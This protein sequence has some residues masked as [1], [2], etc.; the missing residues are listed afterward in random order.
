MVAAGLNFNRTLW[1]PPGASPAVVRTYVDAVT[2]MYKDQQFRKDVD[3]LV[4]AGAA[5]GVGEA[6]DKAFKLNF[7]TAMKPEVS[8]WLKGVLKKYNIVV[9]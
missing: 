3:P 1:L 8:N 9:E 6:Y 2:A 5:W 7:A 4:G